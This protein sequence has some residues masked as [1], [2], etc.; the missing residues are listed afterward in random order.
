MNFYWTAS[1]TRICF[2]LVGKCGSSCQAQLSQNCIFPGCLANNLYIWPSPSWTA[3]S[4]KQ[5]QDWRDEGY[6]IEYAPCMPQKMCR[7]A[8]SFS[9][10]C[11]VLPVCKV[12]HNFSNCISCGLSYNFKH[13]EMI[14][15]AWSL[16]LVSRHSCK[17]SASPPAW[18]PIV[19]CICM[20]FS[21]R[22]CAVS[23]RSESACELLK[24]TS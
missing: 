4:L 21:H 12:W 23:R 1:G 17:L 3:L 22:S 18:P 5:A 14:Y 10:E 15:M 20:K 7:S 9:N 19:T 8:I 11:G 16:S 6:K 2:P 24:G 13:R